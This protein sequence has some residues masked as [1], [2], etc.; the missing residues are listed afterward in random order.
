MRSG[1]H[2]LVA[3]ATIAS[4]SAG[5]FGVFLTEPGTGAHPWA[6]LNTLDALPNFLAATGDGTDRLP[7]HREPPAKHL[8][9]HGN[10]RE[11]KRE[12]R[13]V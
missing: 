3:A 5:A 11:V 9:A 12:F 1:N 10:V 13:D 7:E 2:S 6:T 4:F 8:T